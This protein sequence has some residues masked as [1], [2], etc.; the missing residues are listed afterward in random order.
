MIRE[1]SRISLAARTREFSLKRSLAGRAVSSS[2]SDMERAE[3]IVIGAG[4]AGL[5]CARRL[6]QSGVRVRVLEASDGIGGRVRTDVV[7]GFRLDR[8]FQ[9]LLT[10]YPEALRVL[11]LEALELKPLYS[12]ARIRVGN[13]WHRVADPWRD[14]L[15]AF[16]GIGNPVGTVWDKMKAGLLSM[17]LNA[18]R[19]SDLLARPPDGLTAEEFLRRRFSPAMLERFFRPFFGGVFLDRNLGVS[20]RW[21]QWLYRMFGT[22]QTAVPA[23]GMG[24]IPR[25]IAD[26]LPRGTIRLNTR[27]DSL[28][29]QCLRVRLKDGQELEARAIVLAVD[30][31]TAEKLVR[32][33][34]APTEF[35]SVRTWWFAARAAAHPEPVLYLNGNGAGPVNHAVWMSNV[36]R[37]YA[38]AGHALLSVNT[39]PGADGWDDEGAVRHQ[40]RSWFGPITDDWRLL[41][42][43]FIRNALPVNAGTNPRFEGRPPRL[44]H[45]LFVC[46][47]HHA[48]PS[49]NGAMLSGRRAAEAVLTEFAATPLTGDLI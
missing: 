46:G 21:M 44:A 11:D 18:G 30:G 34:V 9:V 13:S 33:D 14:P 38:P 47:D 24:E 36:S 20:S 4:L 22:G 8:G 25:Q 27:V 39:L 12:G 1:C 40:L 49:I 48:T 17:R 23:E 41:R 7:D 35:L 43:D 19:E 45:G 28:Q 29:A 15:T 31:A 26:S 32:L 16:R 3:V 10:S 6:T 2:F 5:C 37:E 42:E